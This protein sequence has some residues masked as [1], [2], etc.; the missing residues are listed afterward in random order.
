MIV[1]QT[2]EL[3]FDCLGL[4]LSLCRNA[5]VD[6]DVHRDSPVIV[7]LLGRR[8]R[9]VRSIGAGVDRLDPSDVVPRE[10]ELWC[11]E[12]STVVFSSISAFGQHTCSVASEGYCISRGKPFRADIVDK[13][14]IRL[15]QNLSFVIIPLKIGSTGAVMRRMARGCVCRPLAARGSYAG[16]AQH[17][18]ALL[19]G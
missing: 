15:R 6:R 13:C 5:D 10:P 19:D 4:C 11:V 3:L 2:V 8:I 14:L 16:R 12:Y 9:L 7:T 1:P 18:G 17:R